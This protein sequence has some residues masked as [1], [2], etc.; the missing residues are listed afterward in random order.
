MVCVRNF[1][2]VKRLVWLARSNFVSELK[3]QWFNVVGTF[4]STGAYIYSKYVPINIH[5]PVSQSVFGGS[6]GGG[7][8]SLSIVTFFFILLF[9][10]IFFVGY[11]K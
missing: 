7:V 4:V 2:L 5:T 6:S 3:R 8:I 11:K 9:V 10:V 1:L